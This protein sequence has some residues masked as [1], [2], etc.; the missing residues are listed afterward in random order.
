[1]GP[2]P[3]RVGDMLTRA[4]EM[5]AVT[6]TGA[7]GRGWFLSCALGAQGAVTPLPARMA[8]TDRGCVSFGVRVIR[9]PPRRHPRCL[10]RRD[11]ARRGTLT[12]LTSHRPQWPT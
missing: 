1:M 3:S 7:G 12:D 6:L 9:L 2:A 11:D 10:H 4:L 5:N 8:R